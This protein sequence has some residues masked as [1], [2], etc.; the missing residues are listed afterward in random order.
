MSARLRTFRIVS[1]KVLASNEI[2]IL[3]TYQRRTQFLRHEIALRP[4]T[5]A[6][7]Y[8]TVAV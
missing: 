8:A 6:D 7:L 4:L 2:E 1:Q 5:C 3:S